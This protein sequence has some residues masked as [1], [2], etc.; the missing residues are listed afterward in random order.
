MVS[1]T[2]SLLPTPE[3]YL[4]KVTNGIDQWGYGKT[5]DPNLD[6]IDPDGQTLVKLTLS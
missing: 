5:G 6:F 4:D 3:N 2:K 1:W